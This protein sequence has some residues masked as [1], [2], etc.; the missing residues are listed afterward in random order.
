MLHPNISQKHIFLQYVM[1]QKSEVFCMFGVY[2]MK[3]HHGRKDKHAHLL[4]TDLLFVIK[5]LPHNKTHISTHQLQCILV[6]PC[7]I[8]VMPECG[9]PQETKVWLVWRWQEISVCCALESLKTTD[10]SKQI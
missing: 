3:E 9:L 8:R 7:Q 2:A 1:Q 10:H 6:P 5:N 4:T